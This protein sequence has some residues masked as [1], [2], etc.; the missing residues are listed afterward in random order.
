MHWVK[1][2]N[3]LDEPSGFPIGT[4]QLKFT[5]DIQAANE[6]KQC[7][8]YQKKKGESLLT[9]NFQVKL[10]AANQWERWLMDL[11]STLKIIIGAKGI[12]IGYM[13]RQNDM[14]DLSNQDN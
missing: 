4:T 5:E 8:V 2:K 11:Q 12:A 10:E 7:R 13:I 14:P 3:R 1:D 9:N 6:R